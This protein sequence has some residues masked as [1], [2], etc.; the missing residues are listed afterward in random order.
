MEISSR[1]YQDWQPP[2]CRTI[3]ISPHPDDETLGLGGF[4][5][6][7][8]ALGSQVIVFAVTDG[9]KAY[10]DYPGLGALRQQ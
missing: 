9:E 8:T 7:Q 6:H 4:I 3:V 10:S 1:S 5:A 2:L